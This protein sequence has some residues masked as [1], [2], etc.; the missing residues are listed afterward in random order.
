MIGTPKDLLCVGLKRGEFMIQ[1][2]LKPDLAPWFKGQ[3]GAYG[4]FVG[5]NK[6]GYPQCYVAWS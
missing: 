1:I 6:R 3:I 4:Y 2:G 5:E